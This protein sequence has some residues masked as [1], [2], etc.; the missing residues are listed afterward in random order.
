M[1]SLNSLK[2][3]R[4]RDRSIVKTLAEQGS[5]TRRATRQTSIA[6]LPIQPDPEPRRRRRRVDNAESPKSENPQLDVP[7]RH[8]IAG[9]RNRDQEHEGELSLSPNDK[10]NIPI[11]VGETAP[12]SPKPTSDTRYNGPQALSTVPSEVA[13]SGF[14]NIQSDG[15]RAGDVFT[16]LPVHQ[17]AVGRRPR[18]AGPTPSNTAMP[19]PA[20]AP[21]QKLP[22]HLVRATG[23]EKTTPTTVATEAMPSAP[24][25]RHQEAPW[26]DAARNMPDKSRTERTDRNIDK[27]VLGN[28]CFRAWYPSYYGKDVLGEVAGNGT[29]GGKGSTNGVH[30]TQVNSD[31]KE[32]ASGGKAPGRREREKSPML[33]R[34]YVCP[35]CF[36]Y[37]KEL[38]TW[39]EHVQGCERM[40]FIPGKKIYIHPKD[41]GAVSVASAPSPKVTRGKRGSF[42][43]KVVEEK[44]LNEGEW[45]VWEVDGEKDVVRPPF[46]SIWSWS[47]IR[48]STDSSQL[49]CQNLSLFAKLFLDN[50]SVFFDVTGFNYFLLVYTPPNPNR[51]ANTEGSDT[52]VARSHVVGF[53]SKEKMSWDNNNLACILVFPPWQRKGLGALLMGISYEISRREGVMGGPEK[54]I[55]DLG[56][57]GYKRYWAGEIAR[58]IMESETT[59]P[60]DQEGFVDLEECSKATWISPEDCLHVLREMNVAKDAGKFT[61]HVEA[62]MEG[63][64]ADT[65]GKEV[66]RIC[67]DKSTVRQWVKTNGIGMDRICDPA[68]F[69]EGY[70]VATA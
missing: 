29:Q 24:P 10:E 1:D 41:H 50:K 32:A 34:L 58:W 56:K 25:Q 6:P 37:S 17:L 40:A 42:G 13:G 69:V 20:N 8:R 22:H 15:V 68:G 70:G 5:I 33:D 4:N 47:P 2:R 67:I 16:H 3:K 26:K 57:K 64:D 66:Q 31:P 30:G 12:K 44:I 18:T 35:C 21:M 11:L 45:S 36:K 51:D 48:F 62:I 46:H 53:F 28:I 61:P 60:D 14:R 38:V 59:T 7:L 9:D 55:S 63:D 65:E 52:P 54:P 19:A 39:W 27:V 43:A 23:R 49:F